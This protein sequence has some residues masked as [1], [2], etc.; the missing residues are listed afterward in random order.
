MKIG[1]IAASTVFGLTLGVSQCALAASALPAGDYAAGPI[2]LRFDGRGG[3]QVRESERVLV[4]GRYVVAGDRITLT[5]ESGPM[6]CADK[7]SRGV[8][9]WTLTQGTLTFVV[10]DDPCEGRSGDLAQA[11]TARK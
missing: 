5:D 3:L 8:Y 2:S 11:W 9:R 4:S 10:V 1:E 7:Q 6:A